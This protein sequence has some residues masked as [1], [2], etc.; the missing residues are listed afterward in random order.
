MKIHK[1]EHTLYNI[2]LVRMLIMIVIIN[3]KIANIALTYLKERTHSTHTVMLVFRICCEFP[4]IIV[5]LTFASISHVS[6]KAQNKYFSLSLNLVF[7]FLSL[8]FTN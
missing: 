3:E 2:A 4:C 7:D 5:V 6:A 8:I 1:I